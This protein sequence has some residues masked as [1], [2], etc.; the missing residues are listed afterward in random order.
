V[1]QDNLN[2]FCNKNRKHL[3]LLQNCE[4]KLTSLE[5]IIQETSVSSGNL[6]D[7]TSMGKTK[8]FQV[9]HYQEKMN[10]TL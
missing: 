8:P 3:K 10:F 9:F 5:Y 7:Y 2:I 1:R 6:L 4:K